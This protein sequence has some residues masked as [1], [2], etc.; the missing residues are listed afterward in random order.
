MKSVGA[1]PTLVFLKPV[2][3]FSL[4]WVKAPML[5]A[6]FLAAPWLVYQVWAFIAPGLYK[7]E[8]RW[9]APFVICTAG[10]FILGGLFAYFVAFRFGLEFLFGIGKDYGIKPVIQASEYFDFFVNVTLGIGLVFELP[11]MLFFLTLLRIVSPRF[12]LSNTR[13]AILIIVIIAAVVT[14]T[15]DVFNLMLFSVPMCMLFFVGVFAS[16]LLVMHREKKRI[17]WAKMLFGLFAVLVV[18]AAA[19]WIAM[20]KY[21]YHWVPGWPFL[22]R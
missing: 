16:Y 6:I 10:L 21:G 19:L 5:A 8:R 2:E 17:P 22:T 3:A 18:I 1:E 20:A 15:P 12:L 11:V 7:R 9:A 13:Y 4:L 14:P